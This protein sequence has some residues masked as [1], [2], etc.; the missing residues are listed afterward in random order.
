[1]ISKILQANINCSNLER[2]LEFCRL[3]G[4][5]VNLRL[6]EGANPAID[7]GFGLENSYG[8]GALLILGHD[9][10]VTRLQLIEWRRPKS[11]AKPYAKVNHLGICRIVLTTCNLGREYRRLKA[12]GVKFIAEPQVLH[13]GVGAARFACFYD[14]DGTVL[15]LIEFKRESSTLPASASA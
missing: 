10:R 5:R 2:S 3:L 13:T 7:R 1:M 14:P 6:R 8:R 12:H 4:F 9:L 15:E 11:R